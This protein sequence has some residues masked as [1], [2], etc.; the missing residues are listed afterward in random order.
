MTENI[1]VCLL[2]G[3]ATLVTVLGMQALP[4]VGVHDVADVQGGR[5]ARPTEHAAAGRQRAGTPERVLLAGACCWA[6]RSSASGIGAPTRRTSS[7]CSA[8]RASR[9]GQNG[10]LFAGFLKITPVFLMVLAGRDRLRALA[11]RARSNLLNCRRT[12]AQP[13]YNTM[14]PSLIN[15]L[16]PVGLKGLL[17][18]SMAAA[19]MSC[20]AAALNSCATL[21]SHGHRQ[22]P[23]PRHAR[24]ARGDDRPH[25]HR[26]H[27]GAGDAVVHAGRPVRHDLRGHQQDPD[28]LRP[29]GDDGVRAGRD[30]E[31]RHQAGGDGHALSRLAH[32]RRSTSCWTCRASGR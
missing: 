14:L 23:A 10:A 28:D 24:H 29:G 6:I 15:Y 3:G 13:D 4:G 19:L 20:M 16:V 12:P 17:A 21:I 27:H 22:A 5:D 32:R 18:A 9:T 25:H 8:R 11:E 31:T 26:R 7:A 2:L 1:Q 30:V